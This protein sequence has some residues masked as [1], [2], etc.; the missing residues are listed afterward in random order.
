MRKSWRINRDRVTAV[1]VFAFYFLCCV[2]I[3]QDPALR[4]LG[5][6]ARFGVAAL[7]LTFAAG[8]LV[9]AVVELNPE[10]EGEDEQMKR[11]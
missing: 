7:T 9:A 4:Q 11:P 8:L 5:T 10:A 3:L 1:L 2:L 6:G